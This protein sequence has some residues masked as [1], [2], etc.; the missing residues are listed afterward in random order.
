M[1]FIQPQF[2]VASAAGW[3]RMLNQEYDF[4]VTYNTMEKGYY[5]SGIIINDILKIRF[6]GLG[7]ASYIRYGPYWHTKTINNFAFKLALKFSLN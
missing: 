4:G 1:K 6:L 5:E 7:F 3:G 2:T